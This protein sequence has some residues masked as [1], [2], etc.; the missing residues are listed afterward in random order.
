[1]KIH[2]TN[3]IKFFNLATFLCLHGVFI[4]LLIAEEF[5]YFTSNFIKSTFY[6]FFKENP[7]INKILSN[8][9]NGKNFL[10]LLFWF[11]ISNIAGFIASVLSLSVYCTSLIN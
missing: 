5:S 7:I 3:F 11:K 10:K 2:V 8:N 6:V 1:M 4:Y 9:D